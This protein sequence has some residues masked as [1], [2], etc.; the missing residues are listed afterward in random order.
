[1]FIY[2][3]NC[4]KGLAYIEVL[5]YDKLFLNSPPMVIVETV[6]SINKLEK[7]QGIKRSFGTKLTIQKMVETLDEALNLNVDKLG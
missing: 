6:M 5:R 1:M 3:A 4:P 2:L 7:S